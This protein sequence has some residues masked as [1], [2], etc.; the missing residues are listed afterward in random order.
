[1]HLLRVAGTGLRVKLQ[2]SGATEIEGLENGMSLKVV[3]QYQDRLSK[4]EN[5]EPVLAVHS[6]VA[7]ERAPAAQSE[8]SGS[9]QRRELIDAK[10]ALRTFTVIV[11]L[12]STKA[13]VTTKDIRDNYF[14]LNPKLNIS[15]PAWYNTCSF[16]KVNFTA[17]NNIV[18]DD[19]ITVC[20]TDLETT[21]DTDAIALAV[22]EELNSTG[23]NTRDWNNLVMVIP[24]EFSNC[25]SDWGGMASK[26]MLPPRNYGWQWNKAD[27]LEVA[28]VTHELGHNLNLDHAMIIRNGSPVEYGDCTDPLGSSE[29]SCYN[30]PHSWSLYWMDIV[31]GGDLGTGELGALNTSRSYV[32]PPNMSNRT[33]MV[34]IRAEWAPSALWYWVQYQPI[35]PPYY[36]DNPIRCTTFNCVNI[37]SWRGIRD[38]LGGGTGMTTHL[39][40]LGNGLPAVWTSDDDQL[41]VVVLNA[42]TAGAGV[43]VCRVAPGQLCPI[44]KAS[45][46]LPPPFVPPTYPPPPPVDS[47][48]TKTPPPAVPPPPP[49]MLLNVTRNASATFGPLFIRTAS[50]VTPTQ[51]KLVELPPQTSHERDLSIGQA[52]RRTLFRALTVLQ[53]AGEGSGRRPKALAGNCLAFL[54]PEYLWNPRP[55]ITASC[56]TTWALKGYTFVNGSSNSTLYQLVSYTAGG[57]LT[58]NY[59]FNATDIYTCVPGWASQLWVLTGGTTSGSYVIQS[60]ASTKALVVVNGNLPLGTTS[61]LTNPNA[62]FVFVTPQAPTSIVKF[63]TAPLV[64]FQLAFNASAQVI[65]PSGYLCMGIQ[66]VPMDEDGTQFDYAPVTAACSNYTSSLFVRHPSSTPGYYYLESVAQN[67]SCVSCNDTAGPLSMFPCSYSDNSFWWLMVSESGV[68]TCSSVA[69]AKLSMGPLY[70]QVALAVPLNA[71]LGYFQGNYTWLPG[72]VGSN[73]I[74]PVGLREE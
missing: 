30:A 7:A 73:L 61:D 17:E 19:A 56:K 50:S 58:L 32:L 60:V 67:D 38:G 24:E 12:C 47:P 55:L 66:E 5:Y 48:P 18:H 46:A 39:A 69:N 33:N 27:A 2:F 31:P 74:M 15:V 59:P 11:N 43:E 71:S 52:N 36:P 8:I 6:V 70:N 53:G 41:R 54:E 68:T 64:V 20:P 51:R 72:E 49:P 14:K 4:V 44:E 37:Y 25:W 45:A 63:E 57:C 42:T 34:R 1:M 29:M 3:G 65:A 10:G 62:S 22:E 13:N 26:T 23:I 35:Q 9:K 28:L 21:C 16:G 40:C